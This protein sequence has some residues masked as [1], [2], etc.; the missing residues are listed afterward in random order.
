[1]K[2][3]IFGLS[4][5]SYLLIIIL[6]GLT[7]TSAIA[8]DGDLDQNFGAG[9]KVFT[10]F[11]SNN[12]VAVDA[13]LQPD[14]KIVLVGIQDSGS[15]NKIAVARYNTD[16]S[17]DQTFG[18]G[19][20]VINADGG[21]F[22]QATAAALQPDGKIIV[23]LSTAGGKL[24]RFNS[25]GSLDT[26]FGT[27]GFAAIPATGSFQATGLRDVAVQ[28][29]GKI[30]VGGSAFTNPPAAFGF[31]LFR[32]NLDGSLDTSFGADG[33]VVTVFQGASQPTARGIA[34]ST[35]G[36]I[37]LGGV[38]F[39][40]TGPAV[41][42]LLV[43]LYN[44]DGSL[45]QTFGAGGRVITD[46]LENSG[47]EAIAFQADGK[48]LVGGTTNNNTDGT[49]GLLRRYTANGAADATFGTNGAVIVR[50]NNGAT[51]INDIIVQPDGKILGFGQAF[52]LPSLVLS[53]AVVR[54]LP[55]GAID[56][57]FGSN[58]F[59]TTFF[60][61]NTGDFDEALAGFLQ[62]DGK[63]VA[64]GSQKTGNSPQTGGGFNFAVVRY[65]NTPGVVP[66][67]NPTLRYADFDGDGRSDESVFRAGAWFINPS[68]SPSFTNA[69]DAAYGIQFGQTGDVTVP[70][71]YDGDGK[72]DIAV[73]RPSSGFFYILN[74]NGTF[75]AEQFG[76]SGDNPTATGDWDNDG[77]ADLAVYR[78]GA[79][80]FFYY[81]P[82]SQPG[83]NFITV[84]WG[85]SGDAPIFG[86]FDGDR[87]LDAAVYRPANNTFYVRRSSDGTFITRQ[88][89]NA[90]TDAIFAGDFD[91]DGKSDFAVQRFSGADAGT[92][93]VA[94]SGG[95]NLAVRWGT[96]SDLPVPADYDGDGKTDFAVFRRSNGTWYIL[97]N[98]SGIARSTRFGADNDFPIQLNLVR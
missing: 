61:G 98:G 25:N 11:G 48:L 88:W 92:W 89:G 4:R 6:L 64:A 93:Y 47:I 73:W 87:K 67:N 16:G 44:N 60:T 51:K 39:S 56:T 13:V 34:L 77:K 97:N 95:T 32:L 14:G 5:I 65:L 90:S 49:R 80:S 12:D 18:T 58:G 76:Q 20:K 8:A 57:S 22:G 29:D 41:T 43:A 28:P 85:T 3:N 74:S 96:G 84:Q 38:G 82:S 37:A 19:G 23:T 31:G 53:S 59:V 26:T 45:D 17:L 35:N 69:P 2:L 42:K 40:E 36:K 72:S 9:G 1:M 94:Q 46:S 21:S 86:D 75:R 33:A 52:S 50:L 27:G 81:R 15:T 91:G 7:A 55:N 83:V 79:Q 10:D 24:A 62:P 66:V 78:G 63:I 54:Y 70:A 71:D 68:G 30:L